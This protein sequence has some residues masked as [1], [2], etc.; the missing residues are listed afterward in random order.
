MTAPAGAGWMGPYRSRTMLVLLA[1]GLAC[2]LPNMVATQVAPAWATEAGWGVEWVGYLAFAQLPYA[3]KFLWAPVVDRVRLPWLG[4]LGRRRSWMVLTQVA[5]AAAMV[6]LAASG[7]GDSG[8]SAVRF[9]AVLTVMV[10]ASATLDVVASAFQAESLE[11]RELGAGAGMFVSGYRVAFAA[12][13]AGA[14]IVAGRIGAGGPGWAWATAGL[15]ACALAMVPVTLVAHEPRMHGAPEPGLRA[16]L[17]EPVAGLWRAWGRRSI[18]LALFVL[19][20]RLPDQLGNAMTMPLLLKGLGYSP[21]QLAWVR[22]G[23]GFGLTIAG[24]VAGGWLVARAGIVACLWTFGILQAASNAGFMALAWWFGA[25]VDAAAAASSPLVPLMAVIA[26][27][28]FCGG[29]V[30]AGFVAFLM[31]VCDRRHV[32]TQYALLTALMAAAGAGISGFSGV[33][34]S[35]LDFTAYFAATIALGIPGVV[36][37]A[38]VRPRGGTVR[39][40]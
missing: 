29:L 13:G 23:L 32:A 38:A 15:G 16:A 22:Q 4:R 24:A 7:A 28:S 10:F 31:A 26:I 37:I 35:H 6:A 36:L 19:L 20:F 12:L 39:A 18:A 40:G 9:M 11:E 33:L 21:E 2:G 1:V 5:C 27:E 8:W 17:A 30:A 3:L 14:F 34:A 25:S